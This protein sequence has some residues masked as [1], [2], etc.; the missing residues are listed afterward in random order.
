L[1]RFKAW[2]P[3]STLLQDCYSLNDVKVDDLDEK[4][5]KTYKFCVP[6]SNQPNSNYV[7]VRK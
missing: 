7:H 5:A 2:T 6:S 1:N 3:F 4:Q